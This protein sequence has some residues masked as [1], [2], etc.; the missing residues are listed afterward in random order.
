MTSTWF[1]IIHVLP[2]GIP[3]W[4]E[5]VEC[6]AEAKAHVMRLASREPGE[7]FI[8]SEKSDAIVERFM[9]SEE[10]EESEEPQSE[11][12]LPSQRFHYLS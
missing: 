7:F 11:W 4:I 9:C 3:Q 1:G 2:S 10:E 6:L 5:G 8:Y 12:F